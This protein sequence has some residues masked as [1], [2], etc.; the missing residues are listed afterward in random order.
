MLPV[1]SRGVCRHVGAANEVFKQGLF[2]L[3][4]ITDATSDQQMKI[5]SSHGIGFNVSIPAAS[6]FSRGWW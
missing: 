5:R 4:L 2:K 3:G 1:P 6:S